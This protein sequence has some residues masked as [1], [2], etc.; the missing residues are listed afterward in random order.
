MSIYLA[1]QRPTNWGHHLYH[2]KVDGDLSYERQI[3]TN[4]EISEGLLF[5][6]PIREDAKV[7]NHLQM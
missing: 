5:N 7:Y 6:I 4:T 1:I 3:H 2:S